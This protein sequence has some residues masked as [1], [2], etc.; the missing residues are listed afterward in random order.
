MVGKFSAKAM[1]IR[2]ERAIANEVFIVYLGLNNGVK[3]VREGET[4]CLGKDLDSFL[5]FRRAFLSKFEPPN[6]KNRDMCCS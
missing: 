1:P 4:Y 2:A 3:L 6:S 5:D